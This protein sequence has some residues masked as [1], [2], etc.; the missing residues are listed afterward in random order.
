MAKIRRY[1]I[2]DS[3][4]FITCV[5]KHRKSILLTDPAVRVFWDTYR[6]VKESNPFELFAY[7]ILPDHFHWLIMPLCELGNYSQIIHSFKRNFTINYKKELGI[8]H[9]LSLWQSG[10]WDH[11]IRNDADF[12]E[13][14]NYIH[15]NAVKHEYVKVPEDWEQSS[16][17]QWNAAV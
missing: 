5:T 13:H 1:Y 11:V 2:P 15:W 6:R 10:F 7:C 14:I 4:V 9:S 17:I 8:E 3:I 16:Y 12:K